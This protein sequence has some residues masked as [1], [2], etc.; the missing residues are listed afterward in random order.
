MSYEELP[1]QPLLQQ[2]NARPVSGEELETFGKRAAADWSAGRY[3]T[4]TEAV[5][6][7]V[8]HAHFSPEQVRRVVEFTNQHAYLNEFKKEGSHKVVHFDCGPADPALVIQDL[9]D[10]GGGTVFDNGVS[11]YAT[12]PQATIKVSAASKNSLEKTASVAASEES[13]Y[14]K[15]L[16]GL[17][18]GGDVKLAYADPYKPLKDTYDKLAGASSQLESLLDTL[19][20]DYVEAS[21]QLYENVKQ[22]A[23]SGTPLGD[24]VLAWSSYAPTDGHVKAAFQMLSPRLRKEGVFASWDELGASLAKV[25]SAN[26]IVNGEHPLITSFVD[27]CDVLTKLANLRQLK[28]EFDSGK[29]QTGSLLKEA[30]GGVVGKAWQ[31]LGHAG[32]QVGDA[33]GVAAKVLVG[34]DPA[35]VAPIVRKGVQYGGAG[36]ALLAGNAALQEVTD[37]PVPRQAVATF[38]SILPGTREYQMRRYRIM[39]GQ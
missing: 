32:Q 19:E 21:N 37:R 31:A 33:T 15:E 22:A 28:Q 8:K 12:A 13:A 38:R 30:I 4:L 2:R 25:A 18:A 27:Y 6:E 20:L 7:T 14:E 17:F 16:W 34:A 24:V 36:T 9:N 23:L 11:D 1:L 26:G 3:E 29:E 35:K 5:V 39:S 10:G